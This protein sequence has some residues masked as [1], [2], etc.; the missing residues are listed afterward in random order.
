M[1]II[2]IGFMGAGKSTVAELLSQKMHLQIIEMDSLV[3]KKSKR[4]NIPEIF[5]KDGEIYFRQLEIAV[6]QELQNVDNVIIS[7]GG[8]I[9]ENKI[10]LDLLR[11]NGIVIYLEASFLEIARRLKDDDTRPLFR[12]K[13]NA[14]QIYGFRKLL[15]EHYADFTVSTDNKTPEEISTRI[16]DKISDNS[17]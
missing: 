16:I 7:T 15:Y 2:L 4:K 5:E 1:K 14:K 17:F 12:N 3:L 6:A 8:G 10:I 9:V 13:K 11:K